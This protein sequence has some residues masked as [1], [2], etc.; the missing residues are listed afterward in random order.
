M[1]KAGLPQRGDVWQALSVGPVRGLDRLVRPNSR[2]PQAPPLQALRLC[3]G[4]RATRGQVHPVL[5]TPLDAVSPADGPIPWTRPPSGLSPAACRPHALF[6]HPSPFTLHPSPLSFTLSAR[7]RLP[8]DEIER[9]FGRCLG[10]AKWR[11][12]C[13]DTDGNLCFPLGH[14]CATVSTSSAGNQSAPRRVPH[15]HSMT[16]RPS[17][18]RRDICA[19]NRPG[20][21]KNTS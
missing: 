4:G 18:R 19:F 13:D 16:L 1:G 7:S 3:G 21:L 2:H 10:G 14:L 17:S 5:A 6:L 11:Y 15:A 8:D 20:R 12:A 9:W